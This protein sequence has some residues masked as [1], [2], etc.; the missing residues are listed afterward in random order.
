MSAFFQV[1]VRTSRMNLFFR[2]GASD[3][4]LRDITAM[5][6]VSGNEIDHKYILDWAERL[7]LNEIWQMILTRLNQQKRSEQT[8]PSS[9]VWLTRV[10]DG[11]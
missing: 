3:K 1:N 7:A 11:I 9:T 10:G 8:P 5:L 4:H 2:E 6:Q